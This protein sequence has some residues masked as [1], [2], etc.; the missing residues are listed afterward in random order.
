MSKLLDR[1]RLEPKLGNYSVGPAATLNDPTL[2]P[3]VQAYRRMMGARMQALDAEGMRKK[4]LDAPYHL[5][6]KIDGEFS[7]LVFDGKEA[8]LLNPGGTVRAGLALLTEAATALKRAG[9]Q[10]ALIAG[11]LHAPRPDGKRARVHDVSRIARRP[12]DQAALDRLRFSVFDL[13]D[14]DGEPVT[15]EYADTWQKITGIFAGGDTISPVETVIVDK[16]KEVSD[17]FEQWVV[18]ED[19]EGLVARSDSAGFF[20]IKPRHT[21][22]VAVVGF[23]ESIDDREGML[24]DLLVA[25]VRPDSSFQIAG[26]VGGGFT[27]DQRKEFLSDLEDLVVESEYAEVNKDRVAYRMVKPDWVIEI[28]CLDLVSQNTRGASIDRMVINWNPGDE[29]W[30]TVRRLPL[31][32]LISPQFVRRRDDKSANRDDTR[33]AQ[34][35]DIVEIADIDKTAGD[36]VLPESEVLRRQVATKVLKG[37]TMV[38]KLLMWRTNKEE[39]DENFPAYVLHLTDFSPN[40]KDPMKRE[41]RVS[42]SQQQINELWDQLAEKFFVKGWNPPEKE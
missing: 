24:H 14:I 23:A 33:I 2:L 3:R 35:T 11:E 36:L 9:I 13:I 32:S 6:R 10:S 40:R 22:D 5:S 1:S 18:G 12:E 4:L 42:N 34:L 29:T 15:A 17:Y 26:H 20:K 25:V 37:N 7:V 19:A 16:G 8:F 41:I 28:S 21:I 38:R 27:D 30:E 31:A 39:K